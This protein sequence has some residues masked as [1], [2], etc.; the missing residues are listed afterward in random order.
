MQNPLSICSRNVY[1]WK[2]YLWHLHVQMHMYIC[3]QFLQV[4]KWKQMFIW[5]GV[6]GS[7]LGNVLVLTHSEEMPFCIIYLLKDLCRH[8]YAFPHM[9]SHSQALHQQNYPKSQMCLR[10]EYPKL[11]QLLPWFELVNL[12]KSRAI[13]S[14]IV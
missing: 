10:K 9:N 13:V 4:H 7:V 1:V 2:K 8:S 6:L 12:R 5:W 3:V 11:R 14:I